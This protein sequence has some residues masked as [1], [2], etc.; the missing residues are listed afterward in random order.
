MQ[1]F[2]FGDGDSNVGTRNKPWKA[3]AGR[4]Y[5]FS[6]L[7][8]K[9]L[10]EGKPDLDTV[11][12]LFAGAQTN[13]IPGVGYIVN[14]GAEYTKLAGG[15]APRMRI[16]TVIVVWP[17]DK[18]GAVD[19]N[20]LARG[21]Y[22]V[23]AW[24][25]SG[26]KYN[27]LKSINNEFPFGSHDCLATC[28]DATYQKMTFTPSKESYLRLILGNPKMDAFAKDMIEKAQGIVGSISDFVGREMTVQQVR[29]KMAGGSGSPVAPVDAG[30]T[31]GEIDDLV[32]SMLG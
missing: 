5:R 20:A 27:T 26:D 1:Q 12:P 25:I 8:W 30:A 16:A 21:D 9:G 23:Y 2:S 31:T 19:K 24:V 11:A 17:T 28:S 7:W 29:E 6:F 22:E 14:K 32:D 4:T 10:D 13:F 3:D 18:A 15:E